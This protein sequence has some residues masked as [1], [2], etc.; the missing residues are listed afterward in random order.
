MVNLKRGFQPQEMEDKWFI[1]SR[2]GNGEE[3][4]GNAGTGKGDEES[5]SDSESESETEVGMDDNI[6]SQKEGQKASEKTTP[7]IMRL[8][9]VRSWTGNLVYILR[10]LVL[11]DE[12][13]SGGKKGEGEMEGRI[14]GITWETDVKH[15][16][17]QDENVAKETAREVCRWILGVQ[18]LPDV[19]APRRGKV[20]QGQKEGSEVER[21]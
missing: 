10:I 11:R 19:P 18:L 17:G 15:V 1:Y 12:S 6:N 20:G 2:D 14:L 21:S 5:D 13:R 16:R 9:M 8:F 7:E 4:G 3:D